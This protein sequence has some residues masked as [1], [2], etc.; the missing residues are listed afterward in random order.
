MIGI[1]SAIAA[2]GWQAFTTG[3]RIKSVNNQVSQAIKTACSKF[4][5]KLMEQSKIQL[6]SIT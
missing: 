4:I 6:L 2:P 1:L 3:Q 5:L